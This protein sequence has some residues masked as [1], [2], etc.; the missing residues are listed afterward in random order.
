MHFIFGHLYLLSRCF[1]DE[2]ENIK[3]CVKFYG[4]HFIKLQRFCKINCS[5]VIDFFPF[6]YNWHVR[7][8]SEGVDR[9]LSAFFLKFLLRFIFMT[10]GDEY[11][12]IRHDA[13]S[14]YISEVLTPQLG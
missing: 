3:E 7:E 12:N 11:I 2:Y 4:N 10:N 5:I 14:N 6:R 8:P 1:L 13:I 9:P